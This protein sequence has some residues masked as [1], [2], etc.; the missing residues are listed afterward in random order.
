M[1]AVLCVAGAVSAGVTAIWLKLRTRPH[2][3]KLGDANG[4]YAAPESPETGAAWVN[5]YKHGAFSRGI[6]RERQQHSLVLG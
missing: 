2:Y 3:D 1:A 5:T 4:P 6:L